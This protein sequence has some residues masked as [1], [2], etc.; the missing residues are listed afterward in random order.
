MKTKTGDY[1]SREW[2]W[3]SGVFQVAF[4]RSAGS[5]V[6]V[7]CEAQNMYDRQEGAS[8]TGAAPN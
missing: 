1:S 2:A 7:K 6:L 4:K 3:P 8:V 5:V